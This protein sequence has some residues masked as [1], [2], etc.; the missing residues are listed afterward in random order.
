MYLSLGMPSH[1]TYHALQVS[2]SKNSPRLGLGFQSSYTF[3][4]S[5][6]DTSAIVFGFTGATGTV[7]QTLPQNPWNPGADK[8]PSTFDMAQAFSTSVIQVLPLERVDFLRPL[9]KKATSG[10]QVLNITT[11]TTGSPFSVYSGIQQT[12]VGSAGADRPD[13]IAVPDFS[14]RRT[15]REDYFGRGDE[16]RLLLFHPH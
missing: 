7:L 9:G 15:V 10:W 11:L 12:G 1:S 16:Q 4:K 8:G 6:D 3:S 2:A 5:L 13:Q 14:T